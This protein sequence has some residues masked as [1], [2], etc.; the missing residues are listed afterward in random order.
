MADGIQQK[1]GISSGKKTGK[2]KIKSGFIY[3]FLRSMMPSY[4]ILTA[5]F[6]QVLLH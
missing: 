4:T 2:N 5:Q 3:F 6:G 1:D